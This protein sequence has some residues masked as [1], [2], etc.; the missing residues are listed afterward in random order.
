MKGSGTLALPAL[1][2]SGSLAKCIEE[3]RQ[4]PSLA[5]VIERV[6]RT[7]AIPALTIGVMFGAC[8]VSSVSVDP[9][10]EDISDGND[11]GEAV[12]RQLA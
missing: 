12:Q 3:I 5:T 11:Q 1:G 4:L 6:D 7:A 8:V 9:D 10:C 2:M